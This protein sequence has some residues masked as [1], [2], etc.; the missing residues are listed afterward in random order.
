[1]SEESTILSKRKQRVVLLIYPPISKHERYSSD[2]GEVGGA[3]IPLGIYYIASYVRSHGF[4]VH[5][6]DAEAQRLEN[7]EIILKVKEITP[8]IIGLSSTTV[9]F[10]RTIALA[11]EI[12][13]TLPHL[14]I[15][16]GGPHATSNIENVMNYSV[17]DYLIYGEGEKTFVDLLHA[18]WRENDEDKFFS[19]IHGL[20]YREHGV[21]KINQA[22]DYIQDL[23]TIPF[24]AYDLIPDLTMYHPDPSNYRF[25]PVVNVITSRGCPN[26]CTFCDRGV[27]GQKLRQRSPENVAEEIEFLVKQ[28]GVQ[29]I[30]FVDDTFTLGKQRIQ[31]IFTLLQQKDIQISWTCMSRINT[32]DYE[33][34]TFMKKMGCWKIKFGIESGDESILKKIRKN[35][36]LRSA[37]EVIGYC[38]K[39]KISTSGFFIIGHPGETKESIEKT[40]LYALDVPLDDIVVTIN[41]PMPGSV[42]YDE[43]EQ[44]G[45]LDSRNMSNFNYWS[46]VFVPYGLDSN[47]LLTAQKRMYQKFYFRPK[48]LLRLLNDLISPTGMKRIASY[49]KAV[50][51]LFGKQH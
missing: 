23:D 30:A 50:K 41:T 22:R 40:I 6:I 2:I 8:D 29:E 1:M 44:Y 14:P 20:S 36:D 9:A 46:P 13:V 43:V 10:Q 45:T 32:V 28:Y 35:I 16:I 19:S 38:K 51:F 21:V 42:Q 11:Q 47:Y 49:F 12:K 31:R 5:C 4:Q 7:S 34:L 15:V 33:T 18:L 26:H 25:T 3:Q 24:P 37:R 48:T 27:F 39:L 17:F